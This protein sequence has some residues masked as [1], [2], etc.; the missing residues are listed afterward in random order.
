MLLCIENYKIGPFNSL[1]MGSPIYVTYIPLYSFHVFYK[2]YWNN[3]DTWSFMD[4]YNYT[5]L[6]FINN[7]H[8]HHIFKNTRSGIKYTILSNLYIISIILYII[9]RGKHL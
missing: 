5:K 3:N 8:H 7:C 9:Y 2:E 4:L 6:P 1:C